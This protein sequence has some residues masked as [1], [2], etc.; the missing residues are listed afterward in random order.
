M[1]VNGAVLVNT[2]WGGVDENGNPAGTS[3]GPPY[4]ISCTPLISLTHLNALNIRVS[5]GVD[6][7]NNYGNYKSG[8]AS[9]L[10]ANQLAVPD[11]FQSLAVPTTASDSAN[12][13]TT[14]YGGVRVV[15][16]PLIS[17]PTTL[18]P[19][20]YDWIEVDSGQAV[21][22]PGIYIIR[23]VNP[24]T[25]IAL[26]YCRWNG[27]GKWRDVLHH[28]FF[29]VRPDI[30]A[31]P[32][33]PMAR[34]RPDEAIPTTL[35]PSVAIDGLLPGS[36]Y[37]GLSDASS[38]YNGMLI[39]PAPRRSAAD[40]YCRS[41]LA[42]SG[43]VQRHA[44]CQMGAVEFAAEGTYDLRVVAGTAAFVSEL[45]LTLLPSTLLPAA[46]DVFLVE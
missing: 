1:N 17:V 44:V 14:N 18:N 40:H 30:G 34:C 26:E 25:N 16:L 23:N 38:P 41:R 6:S 9:P 46:Q 3:S 20:V 7:P 37:S 10:R 4:G 11:P 45:G 19:G 31:L 33:V 22:S 43:V 24:L 35:I 15:N 8:Q 27:H 32:T 2:T 36:S 42:W 12:V 5:G 28:Q 21:F 29:H 13:N 39:L